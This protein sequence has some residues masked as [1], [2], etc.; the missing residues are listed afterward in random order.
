VVEDETAEGVDEHPRGEE[1][2]QI[3]MDAADD[4]GGRSG[5][6]RG[7]VHEGGICGKGKLAGFLFRL[8]RRCGRGGWASR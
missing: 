7:G 2:R 8:G 5:G 6:R 4:F 1:Q 3:Q